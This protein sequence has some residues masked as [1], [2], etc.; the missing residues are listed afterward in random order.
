MACSTAAATS[1][2]S[3]REVK[4]VAR[5]TSGASAGRRPCNVKEVHRHH[6]MQKLHSMLMLI[7]LH[8]STVSISC[9]LRSFAKMAMLDACTHSFRNCQGQSVVE[10]AVHTSNRLLMSMA[11]PSSSKALRCLRPPSF[12][13][14]DTPAGALSRVAQN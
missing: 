7:G 11:E 9:M 12:P 1:A 4:R 14:D 10:Q 13:G 2:G 5:R 6:K 3:A 8:H